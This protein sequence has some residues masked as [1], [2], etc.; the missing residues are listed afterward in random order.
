MA[1]ATE[2]R[3]VN[4]HKEWSAICRAKSF[5]PNFRSW[6]LS[7]LGSF[8]V[9][10]YSV[11]PQW[12]ALAIHECRN[13]ADTY[14]RKMSILRQQEFVEKL[15]VDWKEHGGS[16]TCQLLKPPVQPPLD[17]VTFTE[18]CAA[19]CLRT[20]NK[21]QHRLKLHADLDFAPGDEIVVSGHRCE[22]QNAQGRIIQ[23][24][25]LGDD[26][27]VRC[28][29]KYEKWCQNSGQILNLL[30]KVW[31]PFWQ[32]DRAEEQWDE[33]HWAEAYCVSG[34]GYTS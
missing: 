3:T 12:L 11:T 28:V 15:Q 5:A 30:Q 27:P 20:F 34:A 13:Y 9:D 29:V 32:R 33:S 8:P 6:C 14:H 21:G 19:T 2:A 26:T 17:I 31:L 7:T 23:V 16:F 4:V 1:D 18:D 22:V 25:H 24:D 10:I